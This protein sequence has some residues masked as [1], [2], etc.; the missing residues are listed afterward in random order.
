MSTDP[1]DPALERLR[2]AD[3]AASAETDPAALRSAVDARLGHA[4][5]LAARRRTRTPWLAAAAAA[6][7]LLTGGGGYAL[8]ASGAG[9]TSAQDTAAEEQAVA[10]SERADGQQE[11]IGEPEGP[12]RSGSLAGGADTMIYPGSQ[13]TVFS[14]SGLGG[15]QGTAAAYGLQAQVDEQRAADVAA[16][17][18]LSAAPT[19]PEGPEGAWTVGSG[20]SGEPALTVYADGSVDY[21]D[22]GIDPW[23]CE[24]CAGGPAPDGEGQVAAL[25]RDLG[26]DPADYTIEAQQSEDQPSYVTASLT[27]DGHVTGISLGATLTADGLA[28]LWGSLAQPTSLGDYPVID[29]AAAVERLMDPAFGATSQDVVPYA[30]R[31]ELMPEL[32]VQQDLASSGAVE[33]EE[34]TAASSDPASPTAPADPLEPGEPITWPVR[35]VQIDDAELILQTLHTAGGQVLLVP[36]YSLSG[37]DGEGESGTWSVIAVA[38]DALDLG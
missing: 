20:E 19:Q 27:V 33:P 28:Q 38:Q 18:G 17:L 24:D 36:T 26:L 7:V 23:T 16:A 10:Q 11:L 15:G 35:Q 21:A 31:A 34:D 37:T 13:R 3:P 30:V 29:P 14:S 5:E 4:D 22:P 25:L 32:P 1:R 6:A 12:A 8:G 2:A 9:G